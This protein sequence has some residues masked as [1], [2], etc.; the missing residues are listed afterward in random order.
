MELANS[1]KKIQ[2]DCGIKCID[3]GD[4]DGVEEEEEENGNIVSFN[5][6]LKNGNTT[7]SLFQEVV[8]NGLHNL[9]THNHQL[10]PLSP[11]LVEAQTL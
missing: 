7:L 11:R 10:Q 8:S 9:S 6:T 5:I 3:D 2:C 1:V 4:G